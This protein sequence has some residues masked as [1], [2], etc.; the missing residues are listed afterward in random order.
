MERQ[1][2]NPSAKVRLAKTADY[3]IKSPNLL[4]YEICIDKEPS[5]GP[6]GGDKHHR[7]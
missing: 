4:A 6:S 1:K 7:T 3:V 2:Q 5:G